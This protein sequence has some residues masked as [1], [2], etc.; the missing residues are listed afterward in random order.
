MA[1]FGHSIVQRG[2]NRFKNRA[3]LSGYLMIPE[4]EEGVAVGVEPVGAR[5]VGRTFRVVEA[6]DFN[7]EMPVAT[8]EIN[9]I[10]SQWYLP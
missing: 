6:V 1:S 10:D 3:P 7:N 2:K 4:A 8:E 5:L 9:D